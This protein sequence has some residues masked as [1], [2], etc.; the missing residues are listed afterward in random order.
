[1][2][3]FRGVSCDADLLGAIWRWSDGAARARSEAKVPASVQALAN[4]LRFLSPRG[5]LAIC[6]E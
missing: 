4:R 3:A 5:P 2:L 6:A 1:M